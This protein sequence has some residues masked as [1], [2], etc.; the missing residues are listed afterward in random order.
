MNVKDKS[1]LV[2]I[3]A[4][5]LVCVIISYNIWSYC[6]GYCTTATL[7]VFSLPAKLLLIGIAVATVFLLL[8]KSK[9]RQMLQHNS[10]ICGAELRE[11][12]SYCPA[13][14]MQRKK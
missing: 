7:M 1:R 13:C 12:W 5:L 3:S 14:G 11:N 6:A 10:C 4:A 9:K 2:Y 8:C